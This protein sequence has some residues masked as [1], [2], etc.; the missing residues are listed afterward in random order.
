MTSAQMLKNRHLLCYSLYE[1]KIESYSNFWLMNQEK[2][3]IVIND[4]E[5]I[6]EGKWLTEKVKRMKSWN[7]KKNIG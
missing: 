6:S 4:L 5:N 7:E 3:N 2:G 1:T